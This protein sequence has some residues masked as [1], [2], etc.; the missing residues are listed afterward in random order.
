M[1]ALEFAGSSDPGRRNLAKLMDVAAAIWSYAS[2]HDLTLPENL[3]ALYKDGKYLKDA[4]LAKSLFTNKHYILAAAESN[5]RALSALGGS[6]D[7][8]HLFKPSDAI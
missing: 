3:Q 2:D 8:S 1:R 6:I 7:S 4:S 5:L